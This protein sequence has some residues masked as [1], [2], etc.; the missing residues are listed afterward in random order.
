MNGKYG[1]TYIGGFDNFTD[2]TMNAP[3]NG[4]DHINNELWLYTRSD[5]AQWVETGIRSGSWPGTGGCQC[6][7]GRFWADINSSGTE[8]RH[9]IAFIGNGNGSNHTYEIIRDTANL[10]NWDVYVDYNFVG[11]STDQHSST[12]YEVQMGLEDSLLSPATYAAMF[13]HSPLMY[14]APSGVFYTFSYMVIWED[15]PCSSYPLGY[16]LRYAAP[17]TYVYEDSKP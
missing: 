10:Y 4:I 5:E 13:N 8:F 15:H 9:L 1:E 3:T 17:S 11:K 7:Y 16:C 2:L 6:G 12:A 14:M